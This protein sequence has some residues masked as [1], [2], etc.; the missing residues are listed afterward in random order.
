MADQSLVENLFTAQPDGTAYQAIIQLFGTWVSALFNSGAAE[1]AE[2]TALTMAASFSNALAL[3]LG[4]V[5]VSYVVLAGIIKTAAE[6]EVLGRSWS[7]VWLPL[8]TALALAMIVPAGAIS[9]GNHVSGIQAVV[10]YLALLGSN[11]ADA[12][13]DYTADKLFDVPITLEA[14]SGEIE[15][16]GAVLLMQTCAKS[17]EE[18]YK[19]D[20]ANGEKYPKGMANAIHVDANGIYYGGKE[21]RC[22]RITFA[23]LESTENTMWNVWGWFDGQKAVESK[24]KNAEQAASAIKA[25]HNNL[26]DKAK[27]AGTIADVGGAKLLSLHNAAGGSIGIKSA[28]DVM[29]SQLLDVTRIFKM[30]LRNAIRAGNTDLAGFKEAYTDILTDGGWMKAGQ[31]YWRLTTMSSVG[32]DTVRQYQDQIKPTT[33]DDICA[34]PYFSRKGTCF[35]GEDMAV[36]QEIFSLSLKKAK[37]D[38]EFKNNV[39]L[40]CAS[41]EDCRM[42][43]GWGFGAH[44][45]SQSILSGMSS[46]GSYAVTNDHGSAE[47][48]SSTG[49]ASPLSTLSGIGRSIVISTGAIMTAT[50]LG[51]IA[52]D[53]AGKSPAG[54]AAKGAGKLSGLTDFLSKDGVQDALTLTGIIMMLMFSFGFVLGYFLPFMPVMMWIMMVIGWL[55]QTVEAVV[56]APLHM[57]MA[58][59]PEG[60]GISGMRQERGYALIMALV[61][62]PS[63]MIMGLI[64]S[65]GVAYVGLGIFNGIFWNTASLMTGSFTNIFEVISL[66][67]LYTVGGFTLAKTAFAVMHRL[68]DQILEWLA[69]GGAR[70]FGENDAGGEATGA[71]SSSGQKIQGVPGAF[72][73]KKASDLN[74]KH[75][76]QRA[77]EKKQK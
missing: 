56:A 66:L 4:V 34:S 3:V 22:G 30:D 65:V 45:V 38:S 27:I 20:V 58:A 8:R 2:A 74:L 52:S 10:V 71:M 7:T 15:S 18:V 33:K 62:R 49:G 1:G 77:E 32:S 59:M 70:P 17:L 76:L 51:K 9:T 54:L 12:V 44:T 47:V 26:L 24:Q 31:F 36:A 19:Q 13:W 11:A 6:G 23:D 50:Y 60:E 29:S 68:P 75:S 61:L 41:A 35:V 46:A 21:G 16:V 42:E 67:V 69:S 28:M 40:D 72:L 37:L 73:G 14:V 64:A 57:V 43:S 63:L 25:M 48:Y 39:V 5:I 53:V 55:V